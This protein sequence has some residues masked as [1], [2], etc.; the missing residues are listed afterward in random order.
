[1]KKL[2]AIQLISALLILI[3]T[4]AFAQKTNI[5]FEGKTLQELAEERRTKPLV[6]HTGEE[7]L[8]LFLEREI[9]REFENDDLDKALSYLDKDA[10]VNPPNM[11]AIFGREEQ[12]QMFN[13]LL[14]LDGVEFVWEPIEA[15]VS[16]DET[17]AYVYGVVIWKM[18]KS[19]RKLGKYISV[20]EKVNGKWMNKVEIRNIIKE[21][22]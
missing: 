3:N 17:M 2:M 20:Y 1:M 8:I 18:P 12:K 14:A 15:T 7:H 6:K 16:S 4:T 9:M 22:K 13:G 11:E 5:T 19:K 21:A 10:M